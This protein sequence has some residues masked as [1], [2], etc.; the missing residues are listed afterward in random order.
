MGRNLLREL[1][2]QENRRSSGGSD[3]R[4]LVCV[5]GIVAINED[6]ENL[7]RIKVVIPALDETV[8]YDKWVRQI[9]AYIGGK[10]FGSFFVPAL[11]SEVV[12]F[13]R[14][15]QKHNLYYMSVYNEDFPVPA[16]FS[17]D[18]ASGA[19]CG[20]RAPGDL[21]LITEADMQLRMGRGHIETDATLRIIAPFGFFV[22]NRRIG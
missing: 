16:D 12:L 1:N 3:D 18:E 20:I 15:G 11:G 21:K 19:A 4:W 22:N 13:G 9:G 8:I 5:E 6:P 7:H 14:L 2:Q 17:T 10:G